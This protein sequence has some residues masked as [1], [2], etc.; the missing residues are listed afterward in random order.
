MGLEQTKEMFARMQPTCCLQRCER[1]DEFERDADDCAQRDGA[2]KERACACQR[3]LYGRSAAASAS[4]SNSSAA[5][6]ASTTTQSRSPGLTPTGSS[7][8]FGA[9][10]LS[11]KP[12]S[13]SY[14]AADVISSGSES[15]MRASAERERSTGRGEPPLNEEHM[16]KSCRAARR[17]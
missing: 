1:I 4:A 13:A 14:S 15:R 16:R 7:T 17:R 6:S 2:S 8:S 11:L 10:D 5:S 9:A 3:A 12:S